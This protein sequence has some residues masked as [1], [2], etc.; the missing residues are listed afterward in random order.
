MRAR[1]DIFK[2][3]VSQC[4]VEYNQKDAKGNSKVCFEDLM[5][6]G[7]KMCIH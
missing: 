5:V 7:L 3:D 4:Q 2:L 1:E 6:H